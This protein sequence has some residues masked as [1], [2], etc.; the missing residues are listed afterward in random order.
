MCE[1]RDVEVRVYVTS[2]PNRALEWQVTR[3]EL[4][5]QVSWEDGDVATWT[6]GQPVIPKELGRAVSLALRRA[7]RAAIE[8]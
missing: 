4:D 3:V 7:V 5:G 6:L 8:A 2:R 1:R